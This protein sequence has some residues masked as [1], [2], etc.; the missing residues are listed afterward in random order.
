MLTQ[1][2]KKTIAKQLLSASIPH[3]YLFIST[4]QADREHVAQAIMQF[5]ICSGKKDAGK[6]AYCGKCYECRT[7]GKNPELF[8]EFLKN[9]NGKSTIGVEAVRTMKKHI[10][11]KRTSGWNIVYVADAHRLSREAAGALLKI[12]EE[13]PA[14]TLFILLSSNLSSVP[15]VMR[16]RLQVFFLFN[17]QSKSPALKQANTFLSLHEYVATDRFGDREFLQI[18]KRLSLACHALYI[19]EHTNTNPGLLL[20]EFLFSC[21]Y[22]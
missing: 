4:L 15:Q 9:E 20:E 21:E 12:L 8:V 6:L 18:S 14:G 2:L 1:V 22:L 17:G 5:F 10:F 16:S 3:G 11:L 7:Y 13:P 19:M